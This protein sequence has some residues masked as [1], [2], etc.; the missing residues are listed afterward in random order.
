MAQWEQC[1]GVEA[2]EHLEVCS[3]HESVRLLFQEGCTFL[4]HQEVQWLLVKHRE[5][6]EF[7]F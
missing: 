1:L 7:P 5:A 6:L 3:Q 2:M 4:Q